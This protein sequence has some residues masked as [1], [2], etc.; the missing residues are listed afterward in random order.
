LKITPAG[1]P[2]VLILEPK[3]FTDER[4]ALFESYNRRTF[5]AATGMDVDFVQDNHS[6]SVK[7]VIRGLH[8]QV[9]RPQGKLLRVL[10]GEIYDVAVDVRRSS[11]TCGQWIGIVMSEKEPR[12]AWIP[13]GFAHGFLVLSDVAEVSY[14]MTDYWFPEHERTILWNDRGIGVQWPLTGT[15][16]VSAKDQGGTSFAEAELLA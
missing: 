5:A 8:Y 15:P 3:V 16:V 7:N 1:L 6:R 9:V 10:R 2:E 13:P 11:R 4:G 14:K 12:M